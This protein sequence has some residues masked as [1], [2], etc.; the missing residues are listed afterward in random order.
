MATHGPVD[1]PFPLASVTKLLTTAAVL[2]AVEEEVVGLD[3]T[4]GPEGSTV[5]H[6]LAHASGL[7]PDGGVMAPPGARRIYSNAGFE[8]LADVVADAAALAFA[9]YLGEGVLEPL[10]MAGTHLDGSPAHGATS[11]VADLARLA[12]EL[13]APRLLAP[14]TVAR[15]TAVAF[16]GLDGVLPGFGPQRP[17]DW[18]LGFELRDNKAPHWTGAHN[19]PATFGHFGRSG[20]FLWADPAASLA[21]V[22]LT[23]QAFDRWAAVA[24]PQLSDAVL[25]EWG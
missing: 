1:R 15:A 19:S 3:S 4:A 14:S 22:V 25:A 6:L 7:G 2:V 10:A 23:D 21:C 13:L 12:G 16:P 17:N 5:A 20:T 18:G 24:W 11:T 9:T 8:A